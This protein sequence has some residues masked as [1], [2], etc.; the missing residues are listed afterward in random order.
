MSDHLVP[1]PETAGL[2][3][4]RILLAGSFAAKYRPDYTD[5]R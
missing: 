4:I 1:I 5:S 3:A 2:T